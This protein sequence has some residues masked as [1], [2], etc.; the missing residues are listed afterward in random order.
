MTWLP[1]SEFSKTKLPGGM[2]RS[3]I[4]MKI[5]HMHTAVFFLIKL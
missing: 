1:V 2:N 5:I 4:L 3:Q